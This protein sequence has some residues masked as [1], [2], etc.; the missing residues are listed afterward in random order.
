MQPRGPEAADREAGETILLGDAVRLLLEAEDALAGT[1]VR[2]RRGDRAHPADGPREI[3]GGGTRRHEPF[4]AERERDI[5][6]LRDAR[7]HAARL[8]TEA[9]GSGD[10]DQGSTAHGEAADGLGRLGSAV[11]LEEDFLV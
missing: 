4:G 9:V 1:A 3:H 10:T 6:V 7:G 11:A 2:R 5:E 8:G